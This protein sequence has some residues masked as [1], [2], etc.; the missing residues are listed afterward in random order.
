[1]R[2]SV[3][4]PLVSWMQTTGAALLAAERCSLACVLMLVQDG[5]SLHGLLYLAAVPDD[6]CQRDDC[7]D[8][9]DT[10]SA[11]DLLLRRSFH[12]AG[13]PAAFLVRAALLIV[14]L[15]LIVSGF[16]PFWHAAG[17]GSCGRPL[18]I[19]RNAVIINAMVTT[20]IAV[21]GAVVATASTALGFWYFLYSG[22]RLQAEASVFPRADDRGYP[23]DDEWNIVLRVWNTGRAEVTVTITSIMIHN[24][25]STVALIIGKECWEG[26]DVPIR[27]QGHSGESW[28]IE[29]FD[30][31]SIMKEEFFSVKLGI[32]L[33]VA[34]KREREIPVL[35]GWQHERTPRPFLLD[36]FNY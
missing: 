14:R 8:C 1:M 5:R 31:R 3:P 27:I 17:T 6:S 30:I 2:L 35:D 36:C 26:P 4:S 11:R 10:N 7:Q 15:Q 12:A 28:W 21:Y 13:Q 20:I 32:A 24:G 18:R 23:T 29:K 22:P 33:E 25:K 34:G 9:V 16:P 19:C